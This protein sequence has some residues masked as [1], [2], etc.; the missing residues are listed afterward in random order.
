MEMLRLIRVGCIIAVLAVIATGFTDS[1][2]SRFG[3]ASLQIEA[4]T[5]VA[6]I[7]DAF[8]EAFMRDNPQVSITVTKTGSGDGAAAL[9][10]ARCDIAAMSRFLE[11]KEFAKA[12]ERGIFPVA[13]LVAV[14]G[15]CVT[16]HPSNPVGELSSEQIKS[17]Y[18]GQ[19]TNWRQLGGPNKSIAVISRDT[20]SDAHEAFHKL[21]MK[22]AKM[23]AGVEYVNTN[24]QVR[25]RVKTTEGA[26][27]YVGLAFV[28][29]VRA[30][31]VDGVMPT[32]RTIT[33]GSYPFAFPLVM[34]TNKYPKL[35]SLAH[36]FVTFHISEKGQNIID[37]RGL[38]P[39]T[40][41]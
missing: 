29:G 15:I 12:V 5:T 14:D 16:V 20:S 34:F 18:K 1:S 8:A 6:P 11:D 30:L 23:A 9:I 37:S 13:H 3:T 39:L 35:G 32:R 33:E 19:I 26:I 41:Y 4:S 22:K 27:G 24:S 28:E 21:V 38:V 2:P 40:T 10:N 25:A 7:A 36:A 31:E 17:I